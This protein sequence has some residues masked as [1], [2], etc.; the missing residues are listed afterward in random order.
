MAFQ[1][2]GSLHCAGPIDNLSVPSAVT[3]GYAPNGKNLIYVS[4]RGDW[5]GDDDQ[6]TDAIR[7]Q[8]EVWFGPDVKLWNHLTTVTVPKALPN[9]TPLSRRRRPRSSYLAPG[10]F[11]CG[12][13]LTTSSINGALVAGRLAAEEVLRSV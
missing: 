7:Q 6:L 11:L 1:R 9:E 12:D 13:H 2:S 3:K 5:E 4:V 10:L 8:A